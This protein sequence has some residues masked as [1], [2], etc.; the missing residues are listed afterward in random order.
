MAAATLLRQLFLLFVPF[1][2]LW[3]V[4]V[5]VRDTGSLRSIVKPVVISLLMLGGA[6]APATAYNSSRF[7]SFVLLNTNAG[8]AF[9]LANHPIYGAE[10]IPASEMGGRYADLIPDELRNMDEASLD[11]ALLKRGLQF[12]LADPIRYL[13]LSWSRIP[14]YFEFL[15]DPRSSTISNLARIG[16]FGLFLPFMLIGIFRTLMKQRTYKRSWSLALP[17]SSLALVF[18][19]LFFY[20]A[21]HL[22]SWVQVRYRLPVDAVLVMFAAVGV[23]EAILG[24]GRLFMGGDNALPS[25][26]SHSE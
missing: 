20:V 5:M 1:I 2:L 7:D 21:I 18:L 12:V 4:I 16:S 10:F 3:L 11:S 14:I 24:L 9:Y 6:I 23:R 8:Y 19:F 25:T 17:R 26:K 13:R 15:P 22:L